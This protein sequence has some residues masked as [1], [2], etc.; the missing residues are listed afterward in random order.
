MKLT[1]VTTG[2]IES[3]ATSKR[4]FGMAEPLAQLGYDVSI[5][6][7]DTANNRLRM[8]K[9]APSARGLWFNTSKALSEIKCKRDILRR[10]APDYVYVCAIGVRNL[11]WSMAL[12]KC[13]Q[14]VIEHSELASAIKNQPRIRRLT[15]L[16]LEKVSLALFDGHIVA[17]RYLE[18]HIEKE[19][20]RAKLK[21]SIHYSPYAF[22]QSMLKPNAAFSEKLQNSVGERKV[23]VYMGTLSRNYGILDIIEAVHV[24]QCDIPDILLMV[25]GKGRDADV[26]K[27]KV[28][29]LELQNHV[30]L[31][32]YVSDE[33]LPSYLELADAFVAPL[34]DTVQDIARC[35]SKLFLYMPYKRPIVTCKIGEAAELFGDYDFYFSSGDV[36]E[37]TKALRK[38]LGTKKDWL[39]PWSVEAH[40]WDQRAHEID[41]WLRSLPPRNFK[42]EPNGEEKNS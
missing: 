24:L 33:V 26:V 6:V 15:S 29:E 27:A 28:E 12:R 18:E 39:P 19:L 13:T 31:E 3:I 35:P 7:E 22:S 14:F 34:Y 4:A 2:D 16:G 10:E 20:C 8:K 23:V 30:R 21:R 11:V 9:E 25:L 41:A 37:M 1:F 38:A 32:G 42:A 36:D 5:L 40:S 17:S